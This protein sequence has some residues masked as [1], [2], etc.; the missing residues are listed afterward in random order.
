MT[1]GGDNQEDPPDRQPADVS[2]DDR[3]RPEDLINAPHVGEEHQVRGHNKSNGG[4]TDNEASVLRA[5]MLHFNNKREISLG[6]LVSQILWS[7]TDVVAF[8]RGI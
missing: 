4:N 6:L 7:V 5:E 2:G 3:T 1:H 8:T